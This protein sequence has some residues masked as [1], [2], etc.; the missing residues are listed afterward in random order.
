[1]M[2]VGGLVLLM[3]AIYGEMLGGLDEFF[4]GHMGLGVTILAIAIIQILANALQLT[5]GAFAFTNEG[6]H[7]M[8]RFFIASGILIFLLQLVAFGMQTYMM[9]EDA[10]CFAFGLVVPVFFTIGAIRH[11]MKLRQ[12][13]V[14][15]AM[16][17]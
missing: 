1:M 10:V 11:L 8:V 2:A 3:D 7:D 15:A 9:M 17:I 14:K 4:L 6:N 13:K 5:I 12:P 16:M